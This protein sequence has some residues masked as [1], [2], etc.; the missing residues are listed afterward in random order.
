MIL[1]PRTSVSQNVLNVTAGLEQN[2]TV[3]EKLPLKFSG[4]SEKNRVPRAATSRTERVWPGGV[5]PYV[6]GGNFTGKTFPEG[7]FW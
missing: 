6:I 5:I 3:K 7:L 2:N 4:Q 1:W